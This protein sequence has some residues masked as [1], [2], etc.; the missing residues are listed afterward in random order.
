MITLRVKV[1]TS[2]LEQIARNLEPAQIQKVLIKTIRVALNPTIRL[3]RS[4]APRETGKLAR[5]IRVQIRT[6]RGLQVAIVGTPYG[7][8]V[9]YG[10][11]LVRGGHVLR[12]GARGIRRI[13]GVLRGPRGGRYTGQVIGF[14]QPK[15]FARPALAATLPEIEAAVKEDIE[16]SLD[17]S[18]GFAM[19]LRG[20][21]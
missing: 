14:V 17:V 6:R 21:R 2:D 3:A 15:P 12:E 5:S 18:R 1:D 13:E 7:H 11:R 8:L 20:S 10:H 4:L 19:G 9:E 16:N